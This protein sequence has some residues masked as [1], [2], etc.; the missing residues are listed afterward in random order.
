MAKWFVSTTR[1]VGADVEWVLTACETED[2]AKACA[3]KALIR[4]L[5]VEA[6]A[7]PG[8]GQRTRIGWR[9]AHD[10]A[11]SSN[12]GSIMSLRRRLGAFAG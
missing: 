2:E 3:S 10:W 4:G 6:G 7:V 5:K 8:S 11:Q 12:D 1:P 9:A